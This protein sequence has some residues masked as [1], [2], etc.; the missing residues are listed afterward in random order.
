MPNYQWNDYFV[1]D[2]V[3]DESMQEHLWAGYQSQLEHGGFARA[4]VTGPRK[5]SEVR[6]CDNA[7][8]HYK[9]DA[10]LFDQSCNLMDLAHELCDNLPEDL[11][12]AQYEF[13]KYEGNGQTFAPH[14]DD[15]VASGGH[16]RLLTSVTMVERTEDMVGGHLHIWP[17]TDPHDLNNVPKYVVDLEPWETVIFPAFFMHEASPVLKGRRTILISWAQHG[18]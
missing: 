10:R 15:D 18:A 12:F 6:F 11:W 9:M 14:R 3:T 7:P 1:R 5:Y 13:V 4:A 2:F 8:I 16:N 17:T